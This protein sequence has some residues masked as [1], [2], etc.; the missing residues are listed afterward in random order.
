[1]DRSRLTTISLGAEFADTSESLAIE[2]SSGNDKIKRM[3]GEKIQR[4]GP[5]LV[6]D[7][8]G[9]AGR[10]D[11]MQRHSPMQTDA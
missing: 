9:E 5:K 4:I 6:F 7:A 2:L 10:T 3:F 8:I 1:M 11:E